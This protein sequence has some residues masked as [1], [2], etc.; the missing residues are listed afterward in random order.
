MPSSAARRRPIVRAAVDLGVHYVDTTGEQSFQ[1]QVYEELHRRAISTGA[2]VITGAAMLCS[3]V[4]R[5]RAI[6]KP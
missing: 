5:V 4:R 3:S 6:S 1:M 2:T